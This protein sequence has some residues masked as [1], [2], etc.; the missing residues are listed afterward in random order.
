MHNMY[1]LRDREGLKQ[2]SN[3]IVAVSFERK[4]QVCEGRYL[5]DE[6]EKRE[7]L[8]GLCLT[9]ASSETNNAN[10]HLQL[11]TVICLKETRQ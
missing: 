4:K 1:I 2:E 8:P 6:R 5:Q 3:R 11:S 7:S 9:A 10:A